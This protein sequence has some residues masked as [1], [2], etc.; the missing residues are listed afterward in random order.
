MKKVLALIGFCLMAVYVGC[1]ERNI[2]PSTIGL[3]L[4]GLCAHRG[5]MAT[6]P[7]NTIPAFKAAIEAGAQMIEFDVFLTKDNEMVVIHDA[8]VD[9]TTNGSGK[10]EAFTLREIKKL[11]AGVKKSSLFAGVQI[12]TFD[13]VLEIMPINI[14]LNVHLKGE[15][16]LPAQVAKKLK[17]TGRLHQA[18]LACSAAAAQIAKKEVPQ[19]MICNM[20]RQDESIEYVNQT[21]RQKADFIQLVKPVTPDIENQVRI[22]K[23]SGIKINFFG[24]DNPEEIRKLFSFGVDFPLVNDIVNQIKVAEEFNIKPVIPVFRA[25]KPVKRDKP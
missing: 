22:L 3:P 8:T 23:R 15:G 1:Q 2:P 17:L 16:I 19:V 9:R 13:E 12:P 14:W 4:K 20:D 21:I 11:D 10:V 25:D 24:A 6:H 18:F 5:A 7:E